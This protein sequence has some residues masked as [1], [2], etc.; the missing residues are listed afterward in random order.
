MVRPGNASNFQLSPGRFFPNTFC[1]W[2]LQR[3]VVGGDLT[4]LF[5]FPGIAPVN[6][7]KRRSCQHRCCLIEC[8]PNRHGRIWWARDFSIEVIRFFIERANCTEESRIICTEWIEWMS[9][10]KQ[11]ET[12]QQPG[13]FSPFPVR[14]PLHPPCRSHN[15]VYVPSLA[16]TVV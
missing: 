7:A 4:R 16:T 5:H 2:F 9:R 6:P 15:C 10:R 3:S 14:H 12:K 1:C 13:I 11:K 8:A